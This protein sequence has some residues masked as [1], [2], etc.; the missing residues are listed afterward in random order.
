[1]NNYQLLHALALN[2]VLTLKGKTETFITWD[3]VEFLFSQYD[4]EVKAVEKYL[5]N[6]SP[7][8]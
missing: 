4:K 5:M 1:M 2:I 7:K 6:A 8:P 3:N